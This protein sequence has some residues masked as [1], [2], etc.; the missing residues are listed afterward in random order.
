[1]R[2]LLGAVSRLVLL[3]LTACL[4]VGCL[5]AQLVLARSAPGVGVG[6]QAA[7]LVRGGLVLRLLLRRLAS[8]RVLGAAASV[9]G[10]TST[11]LTAL[12]GAC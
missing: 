6:G 2:A 8:G 10:S 11:F 12:G 4:R 3:R 9:I 7:R 1:M 5:S